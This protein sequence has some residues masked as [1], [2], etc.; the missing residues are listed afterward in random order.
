MVG[1]TD[2]QRR[3]AGHF[4]NSVAKRSKRAAREDGSLYK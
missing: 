4:L 3:G 2:R 1:L